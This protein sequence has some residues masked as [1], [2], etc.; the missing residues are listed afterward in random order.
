MSEQPPAPARPVSASASRLVRWMGIADSNSA[1]S[2]HGGTVMRFV[3]EAGALAAIK[4]CG[5]RVVTAGVDRMT[6]LSPVAVG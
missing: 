2:I 6:F 4:H 5:R 1:G 3:D